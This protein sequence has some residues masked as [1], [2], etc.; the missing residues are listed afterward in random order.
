MATTSRVLSG[1]PLRA[2]DET[3]ASCGLELDPET[4]KERKQ[5]RKQVCQQRSH[6][7]EYGYAPAD[8]P[9]EVV[10]VSRVRKMI[11]QVVSAIATNYR[12]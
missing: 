10:S 3:L 1:Y 9:E 2:S 4:P 5:I 7:L 6:E 11:G 12:L 8:E